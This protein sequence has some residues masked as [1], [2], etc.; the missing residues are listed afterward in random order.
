MFKK[1]FKMKII[2]PPVAILIILVIV[3]NLFLSIRF[4]ALSDYLIDEKLIANT[5]SLKLYL[6]DCKANSSMAAESMSHNAKAIKAIRERD[7][8]E[9]LQIFASALDLYRIS[10]FTICDG[11]GIVLARTHEPEVFGDSVLNQQNIRDALSGKV[12]SCFEEGSQIKVSVRTGAP[13]YDTDGALI[14]AISAG[15]RYD[16]D[17][18]VEKLKDIFHSEIT[19]FLGNTRIATTITKDGHSII[20]TALDPRI[21]EIVIENRQEYSGDAEILGD[22]YKTFYMPLLNADNEAFA[23]FF[24]GIPE[25]ETTL[26]LNNTIQVGLILGLCGLAIS[27]VL[28]FIII[29]SISKPITRLSEDMNDI[30][31]GNLEIDISIKSNDEVGHLGMSLQRIADILHKLLDDINIMIM[32]HEK[33]NT[34]FS[35]NSEDFLGGY[36]VL[37]E[38][39]LELS[40]MGNT[41]QLT[42]IPNR[43]NFDNRLN[44]E[45]NRA[46]REHAPISVLLL[47]VDKFKNYND[48]HGHQQ[49]DIA[50]KAVA[51]VLKHSVKRSIDFAARWGGEEFVVLLPDTNN[52]GALTVAEKIRK[53]IEKAMIHCA[54]ESGAHVTVSIGVNTQTPAPDS[55]LSVFISEADSALYLAKARGRNRVCRYEGGDG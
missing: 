31:N 21:A 10:F 40:T 28:L 13:V 35:L 39:I 46:V 7:R 43:R 38:H 3:L 6:S 26:M 44:L 29:S 8:E 16:T 41:D 1:S 30:A 34:D 55:Q 37:A 27:I 52:H 49:G 18:E 48:T 9:L 4:S 20:G 50:L 24:L 25:E 47:D 23:T 51:N 14:G 19:V 15:V 12:S 22:K 36:R 53:E 17:S 45:W 11:D 54:D 42:G 33:G 32:E 2:L 5:N